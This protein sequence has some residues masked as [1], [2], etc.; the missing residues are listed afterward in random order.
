M[1]TT[2]PN[3][4]MPMFTAYVQSLSID[5]SDI[6]SKSLKFDILFCSLRISHQRDQSEA[7]IKSIWLLHGVKS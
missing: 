4:T 6:L 3:Q 2:V 1:H 5:P 7:M